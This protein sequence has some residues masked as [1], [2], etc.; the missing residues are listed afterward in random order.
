VMLA[1]CVLLAGLLVALVSF[2]VA[3]ASERYEERKIRRAQQVANSVAAQVLR[4]TQL[5]IPIEKLT[6]VEPVLRQ[7][8]SENY[9]F[10]RMQLID[11][12]GK[13]L[14]EAKQ[15]SGSSEIARVVTATVGGA[16][17]SGSGS[18]AAQVTIETRQIAR[19]RTLADPLML[20]FALWLAA[21][22]AMYEALQ[23]ARQRGALLRFN[24]FQ[25]MISQIANRDLTQ[26]ISDAS[27][28][29]LDRRTSVL[30]THIRSI[31][32]RYT[33]VRRLIGSLMETEP[34]AKERAELRQLLTSAKSDV[35][36]AEAKPRSVRLSALPADIRWILFLLATASGTLAALVNPGYGAAPHAIALAS[37]M[38]AIGVLVGLLVARIIF[39][40]TT[41]Q[42]LA[43]VGVACVVVAPIISYFFSERELLELLSIALASC[44][45]TLAASAGAKVLAA[46]RRDGTQ[47]FGAA[48]AVTLVTGMQVM[49]PLL[50]ALH[51][52]VLDR[53]G[54]LLATAVLAASALLPLNQTRL[55]GMAWISRE[56][57]TLSAT[58]LAIGSR[59]WLGLFFNGMAW[60][61]F[62]G[63]VLGQAVQGLR[64]NSAA[65]FSISL[66]AVGVGAL[67]ALSWRSVLVAL[68]ALAAMLVMAFAGEV[69]GG[70]DLWLLLLVIALSSAGFWSLRL[71]VYTGWVVIP[72]SAV[73]ADA[74]GVVLGALL[75]MVIATV[76]LGALVVETVLA[77]L[78]CFAIAL[79]LLWP[80]LRSQYRA[81]RSAHLLATTRLSAVAAPAAASA[82]PLASTPPEETR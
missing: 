64:F 4:A 37:G 69:S 1:G 3:S 12:G 22:L 33:R 2:A 26:L 35:S 66:A 45:T 28:H 70:I 75:L 15:P 63:L 36:F 72:R 79:S 43:T 55:T 5:G 10:Y 59:L 67:L 9:D 58:Q 40:K 34:S 6:G 54:S 82:S 16:G 20:A 62:M 68:T 44:G 60:A 57:L 77:I 50:A 19:L 76:S 53:A 49:G 74:L 46:A 61:L 65:Y 30:S 42:T 78:V 56:P 80:R 31:N 14:V 23:F 8:L 71:A 11:T 41:A 73:N 24:A 25:K 39:A 51:A 29:S 13:T 21:T 18:K 52:P 48:Y 81:Q 32:E 47:L 7:R 17:N 38:L 27:G